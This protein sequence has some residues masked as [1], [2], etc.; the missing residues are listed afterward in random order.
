VLVEE[1]KRTA[2][3]RII[4][5]FSSNVNARHASDK[6]TEPPRYL[7]LLS[8]F[9]NVH[10]FLLQWGVGQATFDPL[11]SQCLLKSEVGAREYDGAM[12]AL[13]EWRRVEQVGKYNVLGAKR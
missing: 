2:Y 7:L 8:G 1:T 4:A 13:S 9:Y 6:Y 3:T 11:H 10:E 5:G 12:K